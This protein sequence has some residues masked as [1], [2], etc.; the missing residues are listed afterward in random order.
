M[1]SRITSR[2][3]LHGLLMFKWDRVAGCTRMVRRIGSSLGF[4]FDYTM[5]I[6]IS[7]G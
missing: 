3:R 6:D 5:D 2:S 4:F 1:G 7:I